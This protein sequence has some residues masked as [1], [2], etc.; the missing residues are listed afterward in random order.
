MPSDEARRLLKVF[1]VA[2]TNYEDAV[3][4]KQSPEEI[5]KAEGEARARLEEIAAFIERLSR[6]GAKD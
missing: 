5:K 3:H 6:F 2:V 4:R 1:G